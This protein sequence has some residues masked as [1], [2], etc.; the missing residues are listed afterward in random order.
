M[1]N[2][3]F[4]HKSLSTFDPTNAI[5]DPNILK[6]TEL[7]SQ[8]CDSLNFS[9]YN[10]NHVNLNSFHS[11]ITNTLKKSN[12]IL[13]IITLLRMEVSLILLPEKITSHVSLIFAFNSF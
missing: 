13:T 6:G 1:V 8:N 11:K 5:R 2:L 7:I 9:T 12:P 3:D 4:T 10:E